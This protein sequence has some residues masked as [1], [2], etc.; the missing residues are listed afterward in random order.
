MRLVRRVLWGAWWCPLP[1]CPQGLL[2]LL[3]TGL[4]APTGG[5][6]QLPLSNL[7]V[8]TAPQGHRWPACGP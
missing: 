8:S 2:P 6:F 4:E 1:V 5:R 3:L 7:S